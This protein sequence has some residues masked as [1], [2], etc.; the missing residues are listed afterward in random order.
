MSMLKALQFDRVGEHKSERPMGDRRR[1]LLAAGALVAAITLVMI[2]PAPASA[3][4]RAGGEYNGTHAGL[5]AKGYDVV[6]Y[7]TQGK[8][9]KGSD[10]YTHA[11]GGVTWQF[12]SAT[13]RDSFKA[14]P[15]RYAPQYGG[16][17]SWGVAEKERLFDVDPVNGWAIH[18]GKLYMNFN[19][20]INKVFQRDPAG[21]VQKANANWPRLSS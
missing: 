17:C 15:E 4:N 21:L 18:N 1:A 6:A 16:F 2:S 13:H 19:A 5:G 11:F 9:V 7:F 8:A 14:E 20:D 3:Q 10:R 12:A